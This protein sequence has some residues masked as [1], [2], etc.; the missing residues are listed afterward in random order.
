MHELRTIQRFLAL[1]SRAQKAGFA[2]SFSD[3]EFE[4]SEDKKVIKRFHD[5]NEISTFLS[6]CEHTKRKQNDAK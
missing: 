2:L 6:G 4:L 1:M 5:L 3:F